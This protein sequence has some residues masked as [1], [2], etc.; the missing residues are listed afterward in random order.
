MT[1]YATNLFDEI[2][3]NY[4]RKFL[5]KE[6]FSNYQRLLGNAMTSE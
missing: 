6:I 5:H 1:E 2:I 4:D 3:N